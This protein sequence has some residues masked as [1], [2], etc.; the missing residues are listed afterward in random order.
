MI[1]VIVIISAGATDEKGFY[2][3]QGPPKLT[4][5]IQFFRIG[6]IDLKKFL[7]C[8]SCTL[9]RAVKVLLF[10]SYSCR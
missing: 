8:P 3:F 6:A 9:L 2:Y 5:S 1:L 10:D 7:N 4:I